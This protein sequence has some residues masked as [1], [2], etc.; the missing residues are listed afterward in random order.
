M[1]AAH[2]RDSFLTVKNKKGSECKQNKLG[3][4]MMEQIAIRDQLGNN[5]KKNRSASKDSKE[6]GDGNNKE[7]IKKKDCT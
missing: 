5:C 7:L 1:I 3:I 6:E 2:R 4:Y